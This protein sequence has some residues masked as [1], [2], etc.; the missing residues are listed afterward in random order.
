MK[1]I[2]KE[3]KLSQYEGCL[4]GGAVGDALGYPVEFISESRIFHHYGKQGIQTLEQAGEPAIISDDTQMTLF[5]ANAII[6]SQ[7]HGLNTVCLKTAYL[8]WLK[9]QVYYQHDPESFT[10]KMWIFEDKRL[11]H[12]RAPGITCMSA[13]KAYKKFPELEA[14]ENNS[15]GCGSVMRAAPF[16]L[17][18][19][20]D[21]EGDRGDSDY[22]TLRTA[23]YD[24]AL[25]HG[26]ELAQKS[27]MALADMVFRITQY[28]HDPDE[29]NLADVLRLHGN[30]ELSVLINKAI[31]LAAEPDTDD[32]TA[33]HR[34]GE[35][36]VAD[37]AL[38]VA[39][40]CAVR[41]QDDFAAAIRASVNHK[42]D[43]DSTGAICGNILGAWLGVQALEAAF[44]LNNLELADVIKAIADDLY[45]ASDKSAI[46]Q[47]GADPQ[48]DQR[49]YDR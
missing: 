8:E 48:W 17:M 11:F 47:K 21:P 9:T 6:Y 28:P 27:S 10:P 40:Y 1:N 23:R 12:P 24:A 35:G 4:L 7:T 39:V 43:S 13:L 26:H 2:D 44:D 37:E 19:R 36:W 46:P 45:I 22:V 20:R 31:D 32:L 25:T 16:G 38:A 34:L 41:Y 49:Y 3:R 33:I 18:G 30:D 14:A 15:K 29:E 5:A 42:G